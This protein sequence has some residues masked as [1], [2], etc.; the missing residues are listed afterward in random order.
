MT[1]NYMLLDVDRLRNNYTEFGIEAN[2]R[3]LDAMRAGLARCKRQ[4]PELRMDSGTTNGSAN[5]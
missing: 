1:L 3:S 5:V 2:R 4:L